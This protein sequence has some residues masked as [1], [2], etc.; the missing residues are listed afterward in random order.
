MTYFQE[1]ESAL[2][3]ALLSRLPN[4]TVLDVGAEKGSFID[5]CLDAGSP[6][7]FAFEPYPPHVAALQRKF[8]RVPAVTVFDIAIAM[9]DRTMALHIAHDAAGRPLDYHHS[10]IA[11]EDHRDVRWPSSIEVACRSLDSLAV[12]GAIPR[13]VGVLKIDMEGGDLLV[14]RGAESIRSAV[15]VVECWKGLPDSIGDSPYEAAEIAAL[16]GGRGYRD[17]VFVKRHDEFESLQVGCVHMR[18]GDWRNLIF[19]HETARDQLLPIVYDASAAAADR[20][21]DRALAFRAEC[22]K[23]MA[24]IDSLQ[25]ALNRGARDLEAAEPWVQPSPPG[26]AE[27]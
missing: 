21:T 4:R 6:R 25:G 15:I 17:V 22:Q 3:R 12:Q 1:T 13:F 8:A 5:A 24:V 7:V 19:I 20:L 18:D 11:F 23:R 14:L 16:L 26:E 9:A 2:V 10:L 27:R